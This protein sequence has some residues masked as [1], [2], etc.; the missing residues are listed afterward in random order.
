[1]IFDNDVDNMIANV[2]A[3]ATFADK[4]SGIVYH[5]LTGSFLFISLGGSMCFFVLYHYE[6]NI[7]LTE[8]ITGLD[9]RTIFPAY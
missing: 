1:M 5:N 2:F 4:N 6:F 8:P 9:D 3:F 7:I